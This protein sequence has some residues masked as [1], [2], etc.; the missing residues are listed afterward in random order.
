MKYDDFYKS[1]LKNAKFR[2]AF[3]EA[4]CPVCNG[5]FW[6]HRENG[7]FNCRRASCVLSSGSAKRK[8]TAFNFAIAMNIPAPQFDDDRRLNDF[9][10]S[11]QPKSLNQSELSLI[12]EYFQERRVALFNNSFGELYRQMLKQNGFDD[13]FVKSAFGFAPVIPYK[14]PKEFPSLVIPYRDDQANIVGFK[15]IRYFNRFK[16]RQSKDVE[17]P[18]QIVLKKQLVNLNNKNKVFNEHL[19]GKMENDDIIVVEGELK[20]E[21]LRQ[22][23][24]CAIAFGGTNPPE[25]YKSLVAER[26]VVLMPD[27]DDAGR[28][29]AQKWID[30]SKD[31]ASIRVL[32]LFPESFSSKDPCDIIDFARLFKENAKDEFAER[33][34]KRAIQAAEL[35]TLNDRKIYSLGELYDAFDERSDWVLNG[36]IPNA[37]VSLVFAPP[38]MGKT[39][40]LMDV[41]LAIA[42]AATPMNDD[43]FKIQKDKAGKVLYISLEDTP[44]TFKTRAEKIGAVSKEARENFFV[45]TNWKSFQN[46]EGINDIA[47]WAQELQPKLIVI[48]T[49]VAVKA[50]QKSSSKESSYEFGSQELN[51]LRRIAKSFNTAIVLVWHTTKSTMSLDIESINKDNF[52]QFAMDSTAL[53][54]STDSAIMLFRQAERDNVGKLLAKPKNGPVVEIPLRYD[55]ASCRW[56]RL[57]KSEKQSYKLI[58]NPV[59]AFSLEALKDGKSKS[60]KEIAE[61]CSY[62]L[63]ELS[64]ALKELLRLGLVKRRIDGLF[65]IS[66]YGLQTLKIFEAKNSFLASTGDDQRRQTNDANPF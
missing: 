45:A 21:L 58:E 42:T 54:A 3:I 57:S 5:K 49:Y 51:K 34:K 64:N 9:Q 24:Y 47:R 13:D 40:W 2:G 46:D 31:A 62:Q 33:L 63:K 37:A 60:V 22:W 55:E 11:S 1:V 26:N 18:E 50:T 19:I 14:I 61:E 36:I 15:F 32:D 27:S 8:G 7:T 23:G 25:D 4:E 56:I 59:A 30:R 65:K 16:K 29:A 43:A 48:D 28:Q 39:F 44:Q 6:A 20:A 12:E 66:D 52:M 53:T 10:P 38:R 41:C 35:A 17:K